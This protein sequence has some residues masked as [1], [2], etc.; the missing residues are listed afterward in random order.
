VRAFK[1]FRVRKDGT[2]GPL[3][4]NTRQRIELGLWYEAEDHPTKG[5]AHRPG[6][7]CGRTPLAPHLSLEGR[8]WFK[9]EIEDFYRSPRPKHQ[10]GEWL[11]A[12]R[13]KV[14]G[15]VETRKAA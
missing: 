11:I 13:M 4:I 6:W 3:F 10:G 9:V 15:P 1:L 12:K 7:H 8:T 5:Y 2:L 14:I